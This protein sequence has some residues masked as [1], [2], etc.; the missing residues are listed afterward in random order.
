M[1]VSTQPLTCRPKRSDCACDSRVACTYRASGSR[2]DCAFALLALCAHEPCAQTNSPRPT[3]NAKQAFMLTPRS[4]TWALRCQV[5]CPVSLDLAGPRW[6]RL[7]PKRSRSFR[8]GPFARGGAEHPCSR[9]SH[10][11]D[12]CAV[13]AAAALVNTVVSAGNQAV[14]EFKAAPAHSRNAQPQCGA[15]ER[16]VDKEMPWR[17]DVS[18]V[19]VAAHELTA[20]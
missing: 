3:P 5:L 14:H 20:P 7:L 9:T 4:N 2:L 17:S 19:R 13:A 10:A 15:D 8:D 6:P 16:V 12:C 11:G 1:A 18:E